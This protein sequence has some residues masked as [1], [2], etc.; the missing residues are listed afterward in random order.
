MTDAAG[1][2]SSLTVPVS[3]GRRMHVTLVGPV[4]GRPTV[5]LHGLGGR[6][7][8]NLPALT[9]LS[10]RYGL[11][12]YAIDLPN[13]GRSGTVG[14]LHFRVRHFSALITE[15]VRALGIEPTVLVGHSFGGQLAALMAADLAGAE[16]QPIF[17]NPALG[18]PWDSKLRRCWRQPWRF[19]RLVQELG[20]DDSNVDRNELYHAGRLLQSILD[21]LLDRELRPY[22]RLQATLALLLSCRT[23]AI[24][25]DLNLRGIRPVIVQGMLDRSTPANDGVHLVDGFH[26]WLHEADGPRALLAALDRVFPGKLP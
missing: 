16:L 20:Y 24:L 3:R 15:T 21:M 10:Q 8:Q 14:L 1:P 19:L 7:E 11:R 4:D 5:A 6:T 17:I 18:A 22:R 13:H 9:A 26:S 25:D 12:I 2:A 23:A